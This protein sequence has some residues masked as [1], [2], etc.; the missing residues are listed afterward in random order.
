MY[1]HHGQPCCIAPTPYHEG[2][3]IS[4][5]EEKVIDDQEAGLEGGGG[6]KRGKVK[7]CVEKGMWQGWDG[8]TG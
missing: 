3:Y 8:S 5:M 4:L 6:V 1:Q 7:G 2:L